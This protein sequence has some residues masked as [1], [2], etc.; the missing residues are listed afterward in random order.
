MWMTVGRARV[1]NRRAPG[2]VTGALG[3]TLVLGCGGSVV[4]LGLGPEAGAA[5]DV[6]TGARDAAVSD[7]TAAPTID[8]S[9]DSSVRGGS[10][11]AGGSSGGSSGGSGGDAAQEAGGSSSSGAGSASSSSGSSGGS[12][13]VPTTTCPRTCTGCC[14]TVGTCHMGYADNA[15]GAGGGACLDCTVANEFCQSAICGFGVRD[16]SAATCPSCVGGAQ[17]CCATASKCGCAIS[18]GS[19][20]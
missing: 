14:D 2:L 1:W 20:I 8:G 13:G 15:C 9:V 10:S 5:A 6:D 3:A 17:P 18:G 11:G 12:S 16:C 19:C 7:G 4:T